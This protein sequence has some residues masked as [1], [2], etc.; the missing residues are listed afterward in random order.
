MRAW[1]LLLALALWSGVPD[2][3]AG[4][5]RAPCWFCAA[6]PQHHARH[7]RRGHGY[8][9]R[10]SRGDP[11]PDCD[12]VRADVD[13]L[14]KDPDRDRLKRVLSGLGRER[15]AVIARCV[16]QNEVLLCRP[17]EGR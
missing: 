12:Q 11:L 1:L 10:K 15:C 17:E 14:S 8:L 3:A 4:R 2:P 7:G 5:A 9:S 13:R 16:N 6:Q